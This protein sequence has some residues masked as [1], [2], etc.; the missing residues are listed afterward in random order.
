L[1]P[2]FYGAEGGFGPVDLAHELAELPAAGK[3]AGGGAGLRRGRTTILPANRDCIQRL[4]RGSPISGFQGTTSSRFRQINRLSAKQAARPAGA[5][6]STGCGLWIVDNS[7]HR[8]GKR[9]AGWQ[10]VTKISGGFRDP[11]Q[12]GRVVHQV[13]P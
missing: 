13:F 9:G 4:R 2:G 11:G 5:P 1:G 12:V 6:S 8:C 3:K 10:E 7:Q